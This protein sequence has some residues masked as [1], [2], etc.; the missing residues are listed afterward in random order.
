MSAVIRDAYRRAWWALVLRGIL[1]VAIGAYILWRPLDSIAAFALLIA[2][3]A[4]FTGV[5]QVVH[6]IALR[7]VFSRWW[8]LLS[9]LVGAAFGIAALFYYPGLSLAFA[10]VWVTWWLLLT[11]ALAIFAAVVERN[12]GL[13]W[14]WT[15]AFG[16]LS[17]VAAVFALMSPP[18]TLAAIMGLI[19]GFAIVSGAVQLMAAFKLSSAKA[20]VGD[21]LRGAAAT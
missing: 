15:L 5:V 18:A 14:A 9:G 3:W 7:A 20:E 1:G 6:S 2:W 16:V 4:L 8:V 19:A 12:L 11:G 17:I 10:V 21:A 13:S